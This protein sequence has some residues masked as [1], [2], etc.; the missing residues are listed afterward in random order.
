MGEVSQKRKGQPLVLY[1]IETV[2]VSTI[3]MSNTNEYS[4]LAYVRDQ[5]WELSTHSPPGG[6]GGAL[7]PYRRG[8]WTPETK[9]QGP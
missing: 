8:K 1:F 9:C 7:R 5:C 3:I 6:V 2:V 4:S